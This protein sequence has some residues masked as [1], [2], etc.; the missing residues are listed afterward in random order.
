MLAQLLMAGLCFNAFHRPAR[1]RALLRLEHSVHHCSR[2]FGFSTNLRVSF[3]AGVYAWLALAIP[4]LLGFDPVLLLAC[5]ALANAF[6]FFAH[7]RPIGKLGW[8]EHILNTPSHH[9]VHHGQNPCYYD[10]NFGGFF[11]I[12]AKLFGTF[13]EEREPVVFG[14]PGY[15][16]T[17]NPV[18]ALTRRWW[19][20]E[21]NRR[22]TLATPGSNGTGG[23]RK[24]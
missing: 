24:S 5:F 13:T 8:L 2:E 1:T 10:K 15:N 20:V 16:P 23:L 12:W 22:R 14:V 18:K 4:V 19:P 17:R 21:P 6:S 7:T 9:R 3:I 11:I